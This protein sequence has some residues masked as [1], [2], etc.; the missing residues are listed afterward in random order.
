M[1]FM[2]AKNLNTKINLNFNDKRGNGRRTDFC[3]DLSDYYYYKWSIT[4]DFARCEIDKA[5][6]EV[7]CQAEIF[8]LSRDKY[9]LCVNEKPAAYLYENEIEEK[10][11]VSAI[12]FYEYITALLLRIIKKDVPIFS[13]DL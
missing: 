10:R 2:I 8:K 3:K 7:G 6:K 13:A 5:K 1:Y 9:L 11:Q 4:E 12:A